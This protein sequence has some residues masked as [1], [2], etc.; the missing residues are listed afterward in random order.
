MIASEDP[1]TSDLIIKFNSSVDLSEKAES[2]VAKVR[3]FFPS[4]LS[5]AL[6]SL[7]VF[8]SFSF[9]R[10]IK[11]SPAFAAPLIPKISTGEDGGA[12]LILLPKSLIIAL[13]FPHFK[14]LTKKSPFFNV[15]VVT[16]IDATGPLPMS[17]FDSKTIPVA[18]DS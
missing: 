9:S 8:A 6:F 4:L 3:G 2:W 14:P 16:I 11:S 18:L 10:T 1:W 15:P 7:N 12:S 17:I 5:S 13:T